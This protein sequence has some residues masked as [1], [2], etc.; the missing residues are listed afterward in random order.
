MVPKN[1][2]AGTSTD[3]TKHCQDPSLMASR[4]KPRK[5]KTI[6]VSSMARPGSDLAR[7]F[8]RF[9]ALPPSAAIGQRALV[10]YALRFV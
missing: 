5:K 3:R 2:M 7:C 4:K 1:T 6:T 10:L 9:M 8:L